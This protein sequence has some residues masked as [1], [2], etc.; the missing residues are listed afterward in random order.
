MP[1]PPKTDDVN[2]IANGSFDLGATGWA[3][4]TNGVGEYSI[5]PHAGG[6]AAQIAVTTSGTNVQFN[7]SNI[8]MHKETRYLLRFSAMSATG[9]DCAVSIQRNSAPY[10]AY[11]LWSTNIDL[12]STWSEYVVEFTSVLASD[13]VSDA[14][15]LF[16]FAGAARAGDQYQLDD[17]SLKPLYAEGIV[18]DPPTILWP[19]SGSTN[20]PST[21]SLNWTKVPGVI[22]YTV[23]LSSD[24]QFVDI[25]DNKMVGGTVTGFENLPQTSMVYARV[26]SIG[27]GGAGGFSPTV[28][29]MAGPATSV[30][31]HPEVPSRFALA[32]NYPNPFNPT[33]RIRYSLPLSGHVSLRVYNALGAVVGVAEEG[34]RSAGEHEVT[35]DGGGLASG[36]YFIRMQS[37]S[38]VDTRKMVLLR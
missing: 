26:Q 15:L 23:E 1:P 20:H 8:V 12:T 11:G 19:L 37:G 16:W 24:S 5:V 27:A 32:Q 7:Q 34:E 31:S 9:S 4:F 33:T 6:S 22:S 10:N 21:V 30:E 35:F 18:P 3:F 29:F 36:L 25:I 28:A 2:A 14:R 13:S 38:F 17:I